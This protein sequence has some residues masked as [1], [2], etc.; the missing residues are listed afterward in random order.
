MA[1][2]IMMPEKIFSML[3][4]DKNKLPQPENPVKQKNEPTMIIG[5]SSEKIQ[6]MVRKGGA[7]HRPPA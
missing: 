2:R 4:L 1:M 7:E 6:G 5:S 3:L